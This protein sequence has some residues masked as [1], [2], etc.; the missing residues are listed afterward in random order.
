MAALSLRGGVLAWGPH[1]ADGRAECSMR[2]R[3]RAT[4]GGSRAPRRRDLARARLAVR[5]GHRLDPPEPGRPAPEGPALPG[6]LDLRA[7]GHEPSEELPQGGGAAARQASPR[8]PFIFDPR[9]GH[10]TDFAADLPQTVIKASE[11]GYLPADTFV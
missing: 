8:P 9:G 4:W 5:N 11:R 1:P 6:H 10:L 7:L 2:V 3:G